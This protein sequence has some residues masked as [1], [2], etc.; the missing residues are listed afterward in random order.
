MEIAYRTGAALCDTI[1]M[2]IK[3]FRF[4]TALRRVSTWRGG[5]D[6]VRRRLRS[7]CDP[8]TTFGSLDDIVN[9]LSLTGIVDDCPGPQSLPAWTNLHSPRLTL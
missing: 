7:R 3:Q 9:G 6:Y 1:T 5:S 4:A 2:F 8:G